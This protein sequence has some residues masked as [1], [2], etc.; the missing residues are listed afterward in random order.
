MFARARLSIARVLEICG[1]ETHRRTLSIV[2]VRTQYIVFNSHCSL[3]LLLARNCVALRGPQ[4]LSEAAAARQGVPNTTYVPP[5]SPSPATFP[6]RPPSPSGRP[7]HPATAPG[8]SP[9]A[10]PAPHFPHPPSTPT[11]GPQFPVPSFASASLQNPPTTTLPA[12]ASVLPSP[13]S[14]AVAVATVEEAS[15]ASPQFG[16][17]SNEGGGAGEGVIGNVGAQSEPI[18][19]HDG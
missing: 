10:V 11:D 6:T 8:R 1:D 4:D 13:S 12:T 7:S 2:G 19:G 15:L 16:I 14:S 9:P 3:L 18:T 17:A 5:P